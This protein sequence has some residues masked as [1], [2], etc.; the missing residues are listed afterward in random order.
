MARYGHMPDL[1]DGGRGKR[2]MES[3]QR[4]SLA[5]LAAQQAEIDQGAAQPT[6]SPRRR[7]RGLLTFVQ[8]LGGS[9]EI[10]LG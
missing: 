2:A 5:Q 10:N 4:T 8:G 3:Q 6:G 1:L 9:G 7:G